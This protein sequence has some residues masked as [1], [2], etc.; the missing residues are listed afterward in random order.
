M[1]D[2]FGVIT[3][4]PA[5]VIQ[6]IERPVAGLFFLG[7]VQLPAHRALSVT[8]R[9]LVAPVALHE[10]AAVP[11]D[12]HVD[13]VVLQP[14]V[15][16]V[17]ELMVLSRR[18]VDDV[19]HLYRRHCIAT[20]DLTFTAQDVEELLAIFMLVVVRLFA[21]LDGVNGKPAQLFQ[22]ASGYTLSGIAPVGEF[23][24]QAI[25]DDRALVADDRL[26]LSPIHYC[27]HGNPLLMGDEWASVLSFQE[28]VEVLRAG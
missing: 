17:E 27:W 11:V 3:D 20:Q 22:H 6:I 4:H 25:P 18:P 2:L 28:T 16:G 5:A 24:L 13:H 14:A 1:P 8:Q 23:G 9:R 26:G 15:S 19:A 12:R 7:A 21:P 10:L